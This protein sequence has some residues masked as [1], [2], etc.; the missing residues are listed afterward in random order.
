MV[1]ITLQVPPYSAVWEYQ[2]F[3]FAN[4][5]FLGRNLG[6]N[7]GLENFLSYRRVRIPALKE[8]A[9]LKELVKDIIDRTANQ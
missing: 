8:L 2:R 7:F 5:L 9:D 4:L 3:G 6:L 1:I